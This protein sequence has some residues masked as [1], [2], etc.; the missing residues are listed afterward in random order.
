[1]S[2]EEDSNIHNIQKHQL[3][4]GWFQHFI[5][6]LIFNI[7]FWFWFSTFISILIFNI[8]FWFWFSTF[9]SILIFRLWWRGRFDWMMDQT[10]DFVGRRRK[11][12][13]DE[14][15]FRESSRRTT[16]PKKGETFSTLEW[17]LIF[18]TFIWEL[19]HSVKLEKLLSD[20]KFVKVSISKH[21]P[22]QIFLLT[23]NVSSLMVYL[24]ILG[25]HEIVYVIKIFIYWL[26]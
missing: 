23:S 9:I 25:S 13:S 15:E 3:Q 16:Q 26:I 24:S 12:Q 19:S 11:R 1:M 10:F 21:F 20:Y 6:I 5:S 22:F 17:L 18:T 4:R 14:P 8:L 7:S 2:K